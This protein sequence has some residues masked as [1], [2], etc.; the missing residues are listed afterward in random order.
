[1]HRD[2]AA[3]AATGSRRAA[4]VYAMIKKDEALLKRLFATFR[5]EASEHLLRIS[6]GLVE[7]EKDSSAKESKKIVEAIFREAHSFKGAAGSLNLVEIEAVCQAIE[8]LF[9]AIKRSELLPSAP[10]FDA[11]HRAADL[12]GLLAAS[13]EGPVAADNK[14]Q[15]KALV[16]ELEDIVRSEPVHGEGGPASQTDEPASAG[17]DRAVA[18]GRHSD[19]LG[20]AG[21]V[22]ADV[23][24]IP[25]F[26]EVE[27]VRISAARLDSIMLQTEELISEKLSM[28][29]RLSDVREL[30]QGLSSWT[31]KRSAVPPSFRFEPPDSGVGRISQELKP[32][33]GELADYLKGSDSLLKSFEQSIASLE[34]QAEADL[35]LFSSKLDGLLADTKKALMLPLNSLTEIFP[36]LVRDLSHAQGKKVELTIRGAELE[37][38]RR[39]LEEIRSPMIHIVRNCVDHGIE[40]REERKLLGK[41]ETGS[42]VIE[43]TPRNG[44]KVE[45]VVG[46]DGRGMDAAKLKASALKAGLI[47][48][49]EADQMGE[50]DCLRLAFVS[51]VS[52][53]PVITDVSGRGLGLAIVSDKVQNLGGRVSV[54]SAEGRGSTFRLILPVTLATFRGVLVRVGGQFFIVPSTSAERV[55][56]LEADRVRT[57]E[58]RETVEFDGQTLPLVALGQVLGIEFFPARKAPAG[59]VH[60]A[61]L[62]AG[63][64][65]IA[66]LVDEVIGEQEVL[67]KRLGNQLARVKCISGA[68]VTGSGRV[69][70]VLNPGDLM[71]AALRSPAQVRFDREETRAADSVKKK[72]L[73]IE[74]SITARTLLKNILETAGYEVK[75][76]VDGLDGY[77]LLKAEAFDLVVSDVDMPR[78]NGLD[79][80]VKI[81]AD[82]SL[83]DLP[84][85]LVTALSSPGDRERGID[86]GAN[87]YIVKSSF[88]QSNLLEVI[89]RLI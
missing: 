81:R 82:Q 7:L 64:T 52:T 9:A 40:S 32:H 41:P 15:V 89:R 4:Q 78:M 21:A 66:F 67:L 22:A 46:D 85:V 62:S 26:A 1:M 88:D 50:A 61:V 34:A 63:D 84:V 77:Q 8:G 76:A 5:T 73:V 2:G 20:P 14:A 18:P 59:K 48:Q 19:P 11:L 51:G 70:P 42:I 30:R 35:R 23:V 13:P 37:L 49:P 60:I 74:D 45:I 6:S 65:R 28:R 57:V 58:N 71:N 53:N 80:T 86:A 68:T 29:Q 16:R 55:L 87:A 36:K 69:V 39:I 12:L 83:A 79:L 47:T 33:G 3:L 31:R 25:S 72:L 54:E 24:D 10:L 43:V 75:T 56:R 17:K 27:T 44:D 38:D